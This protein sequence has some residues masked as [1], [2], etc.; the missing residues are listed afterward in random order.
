MSHRVTRSSQR[1]SGRI[2]ASPTTVEAS[3]KKRKTPSRAVAKKTAKPIP[4]PQPTSDEEEEVDE[5]QEVDESSP[6]AHV[7]VKYLI[8]IQETHTEKES[9]TPALSR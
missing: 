6:Y 5:L 3:A 9:R 7:F 8:S 4:P 2:Q 1:E